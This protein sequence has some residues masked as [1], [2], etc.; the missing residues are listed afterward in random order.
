MQGGAAVSKD[1]PPFMVAHEANTLCG[2]NVVGMRRAGM[3]AADRQELKQVYRALFREGKNL[4]DAIPAAR[5]KFSSQPA[6]V[7]LDFIASS[8]RGICFDVGSR[9]GTTPAEQE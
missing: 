6:K 5:K 8:K 2:L 9:K 1:L 4:R 7:M 3:S